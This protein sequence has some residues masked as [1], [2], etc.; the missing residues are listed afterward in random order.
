MILV[1]YSEDGLP[2]PIAEAV[3]ENI[4]PLIPP[5]PILLNALSINLLFAITQNTRGE[6]QLLDDGYLSTCLW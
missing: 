1:G 3:S 6:H 2:D 4:L 5:S